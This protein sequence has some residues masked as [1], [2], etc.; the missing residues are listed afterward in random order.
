MTWPYHSVYRHHRHVALIVYV[1][2]RCKIHS[3]TGMYQPNTTHMYAYLSTQE[4]VYMREYNINWY[5][6][7]LCEISARP[8]HTFSHFRRA[9]SNFIPL[10]GTGSCPVD[11][12]RT[13][14]WDLRFPSAP[15]PP[16]IAAVISAA[17]AFSSRR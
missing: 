16:R 9:R 4:V 3:T 7:H 6:V 13:P 10:C 12:H 17:A 8:P 15:P 11:P 14:P 5:I 2:S 1:L